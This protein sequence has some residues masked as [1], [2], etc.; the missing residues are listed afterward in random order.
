M[1]RE[2]SKTLNYPNGFCRQTSA[3]SNLYIY[4]YFPMENYRKLI[5]SKAK[6]VPQ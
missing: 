6:K 5:C 1:I 4:F 2:N 3:F